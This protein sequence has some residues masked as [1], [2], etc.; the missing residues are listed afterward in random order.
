M[1]VCAESFCHGGEM[2]VLKHVGFLHF[3][4]DWPTIQKGLGCTKKIPKPFFWVTVPP[5]ENS[6]ALAKACQ[7][8]QRPSQAYF[9]NLTYRVF[10]GGPTVL[11]GPCCCSFYI[12]PQRVAHN[13]EGVGCTQKI[14]SIFFFFRTQNR[15]GLASTRQQRQKALSCPGYRRT[16]ACGFT[17]LSSVSPLFSAELKRM[18][19]ERIVN[20]IDPG[21]MAC[22]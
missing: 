11:K 12:F 20:S 14:P 18:T 19:R 22:I 5:L 10:P 15:G 8:R 4:R 17:E 16:E 3:E 9:L 13:L 6:R 7:Q 2:G 21:V 1:L